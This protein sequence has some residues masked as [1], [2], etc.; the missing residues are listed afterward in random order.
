MLLNTKVAAAA[1]Q[2]AYRQRFHATRYA[3]KAEQIT[4]TRGTMVEFG[5]GGAIPGGDYQPVRP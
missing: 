1:T 4:P 5:H 2:V 3:Q